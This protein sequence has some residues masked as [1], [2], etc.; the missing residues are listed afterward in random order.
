MT[1]ENMQLSLPDYELM[2]KSGMHFGRKKTIFHPNMQPYIYTSRE[3]V[4]ILD[5]IKTSDML[6]KAI[7][8]MATMIK[9]GKQILFVGT[10]KQ[11]IDLVKDNAIALGMPYVTYRWLGGTLTNFKVIINR[12]KYMEQLEQEKVSG[13]SAKYTKKERLM[14][15]REIEKL[16]QK[17]DGLRK[18]NKVPDAVFI[19]SLKE[20]GLT[21]REAKRVKVKTFG[22]VNTDSNP[23]DLDF[24]IPANDNA[25][26]SI[27][28]ILK[29]I[30]D[31]LKPLIVSKIANI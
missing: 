20:N 19:S 5:L 17:Y 11:S 26:M 2:L 28:L 29:A 27:E 22:I 10:A 9:E 13:T 4:Y 7:K 23:K 18:L 6:A 15:E 1:I 30:S 14:K 31:S 21:I 25:R 12:V 8:A 24:P 16:K 3:N